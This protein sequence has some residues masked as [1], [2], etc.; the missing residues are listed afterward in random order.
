MS[1]L[2]FARNKFWRS[3]KSFEEKPEPK[4]DPMFDKL[5]SSIKDELGL[6]HITSLINAINQVSAHFNDEYVKDGN[7]RNAS[8]DAVCEVFQGLKKNPS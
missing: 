2:Q 4:G 7:L 1:L 3:S 6:A 5:F 8:L